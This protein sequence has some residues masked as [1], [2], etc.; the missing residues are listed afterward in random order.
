[1]NKNTFP[2]QAEVCTLRQ[3]YPKGT[4]VELVSMDDAYTCL[5]PG[6]KGTVQFVDDAGTVHIQWDCNS[7]L[8]GIVY[9]VDRIKKLQN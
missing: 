6:E 2:S 5:K 1:M 4:R 7:S 3:Q 8:L 9:G